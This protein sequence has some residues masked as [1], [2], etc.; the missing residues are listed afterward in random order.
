MFRD[1]DI[2]E[3]IGEGS[4]GRVFKVQHRDS[5][6]IMAM[7][8][9][10]K[11]FLIQ[12]QQLKYAVSEAQIMQMLSQSP[13]DRHPYILKL[14]FSFQTPLHLYM[15]TEFCENGDLSWHLDQL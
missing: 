13:K 15:V 1:F 3:M 7:K 8:A 6:L 10:K 11:Q 5:G 4:F 9:M 2:L 14:F 12:N